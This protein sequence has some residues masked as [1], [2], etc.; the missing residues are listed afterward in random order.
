MGYLQEF[1]RSVADP[2][3]FW[4]Q[5]AQPL[6]WFR[7]PQVALAEDD[8]GVPRWFADGELNTAYLALDHHVDSGR[9]EQPAL[10]YDSPV[11][12]VVEHYTYRQL[13]CY[14]TQKNIIAVISIGGRII[15]FHQGS[16]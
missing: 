11:T 14:E 2:A 9:G 6:A 8:N 12:G 3:S 13:L 10:I 16:G 7:R 1:E 5:Q 15:F 4:L